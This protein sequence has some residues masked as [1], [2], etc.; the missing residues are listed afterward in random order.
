MKK[1]LIGMM[2]ITGVSAGTLQQTMAMDVTSAASAVHT[3]AGTYIGS[4]YDALNSL[5]VK[6]G[7]IFGRV[8][9]NN[10]QLFKLAKAYC[11]LFKNS[12]LS[13]SDLGSA[14]EKYRKHAIYDT[15]SFTFKSGNGQ[16]IINKID[17]A[18]NGTVQQLPS[19]SASP[20]A[21]VFLRDVLEILANIKLAVIK[22]NG[23][24]TQPQLMQQRYITLGS[25]QPTLALNASNGAVGASTLGVGL[26]GSSALGIG[27]TGLRSSTYGTTSYSSNSNLN[28][29]S[30]TVNP[31]TSSAYSQQQYPSAG[32]P[33][34]VG[35]IIR[36]TSPTYGTGSLYNKY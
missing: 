34:Q 14:T 22:G 33:Q 8:G 12:K 26:S 16:D 13:P 4:I 9:E 25:S 11:K 32:Y 7:S 1:I 23:M 15:N 19:Q 20:V 35:G 30:M 24:S 6:S 36:T 18:I 29:N 21:Q 3:I 27:N 5:S 31:L 17:Y 2:L 28:R 10:N